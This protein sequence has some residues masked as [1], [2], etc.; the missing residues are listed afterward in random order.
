MVVPLHEL[1]IQELHDGYESGAFTSLE[2]TACLLERIEK[3]NPELNAF[4]T[5]SDE[6]ARRQAT[7]ADQRRHEGRSLGPLDGIPVA[8]KDVLLTKGIRT[9]AASRIL[10]NFIPPLNATVV[11]RLRQS[12]AV[13]IGK[14]N[15]DEFAMGSSSENSAFGPVQHP[16][17]ESRVPG[18]SSGGSAA[19]VA[20]R[21]APAALGTDTGGSIRQP[22]AFTGIVGLKPTYGRVSR[23][24][25]VAFA[26][27][28]DQVGPMARNV[29]DVAAVLDCIAG[30]DPQD[31]TSWESESADNFAAAAALGSQRSPSFRIGLPQEYFG[32][33]VDSEVEKAVRQAIDLLADA[34]CEVSQ[35]RLPTT[36]YAV[37]TYYLIATAEASSNL[38]RYDGIRYGHRSSQARS[39]RE[40]YRLSRSEGFGAEVKRRILLGTYAL[41]AGYY[42]EYYHKAAQVR[43]LIRQDFETAFDHVDLILTPTTPTTAFR[44]GEKQDP[45]QMYLADVFTVAASL[46]GLPGISLPCGQDSEGAPIG[47]QMLAPWFAEE[48]LLEAA[49]GAELLLEKGLP[50]GDENKGAA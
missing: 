13:V 27:S 36:E 16:F 29:S 50:P 32:S 1:G 39:L 40:A 19:A 5:V 25:V 34:G 11:D 8:L 31:S 42:D 30:F 43:R 14:T 7:A 15:L 9:T 24:G 2:V 17:L 44:L 26:S 18:G 47:L 38:S 33:G 45:L 23:C 46:A 21:L 35:I 10:D 22:A 37:A 4:L 41:S 49:A 12:G 28:L 48:S 6:H 20:A 3:A